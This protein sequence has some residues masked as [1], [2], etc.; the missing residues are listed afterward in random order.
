[1]AQDR[2][3]YGYNSETD[4]STSA[5]EEVVGESGP[6]GDGVSQE[7]FG[8][9]ET[10]VAD[11]AAATT[12]ALAGK[13]ST[14]SVAAKASQASLD[15]LGSSVAAKAD[16]SAVTTLAGRVTAVEARPSYVVLAPGAP[17]PPETPDDTLVFRSNA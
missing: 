3:R 12:T 14:A 10:S 9:L 4:T 15:A 1:M 13:A 7:D 17:L 11:L 16:A 2:G 6:G 8:V 5:A